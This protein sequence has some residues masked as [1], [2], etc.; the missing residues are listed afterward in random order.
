MSAFAVLY[1]RSGGPL[2]PGLLERVMERL[3]HRGP[4]GQDTFISGPLAMGHWHFWTTPE[5]D[6]ERQPLKLDGLPFTLVF[7][8]RLD[9]REELFAALSISAEEGRSLSDAALVLR[10]YAAWGQGCVERFI[11]E[12]AIVIFDER[13]HTLFCARDHLGDR[14]LFYAQQG[15]RV[16]I[17]SEPWA[18]VGAQSAPVELDER[19]VAY[20]FALRATP[21]GQTLFKDVIELL[22]ANVILI[23]EHG[24]RLQRYWQP[25]YERKIRYKTDQEYADHFRDLLEESVRC[26]MRSTTPVAVLMSGGLDSTSV[27]S[28]AARMIAPQQLTTISYVFDEITA[29]DEREFINLMVD[30][31]NLNSIQIPCDDVWP[32]KNW[33]DWPHNAS[34]PMQDLYFPMKERAYRSANQNKI[35][36][37]LTGSFGDL[38]YLGGNYWL[39]DLLEDGYYKE[40]GQEFL[41]HAYY[42][43][44]LW[45]LQN[46]HVQP[47]IRNLMNAIP[48]LRTVRRK[49]RP[50]IWL[51]PQSAKHLS[52][53]GVQ[54]DQ[55]A[56]RNQHLVGDNVNYG[57]LTDVLNTSRFM[58]E[59]RDPYRDRRLVEFAMSLPAYQLYYRGLYKR[60]L[61]KAM[62]GLLPEP[63][64]VSFLRIDLAAF[65]LY[66]FEKEKTRLI[67]YFQKPGA[68][69]NQSVKKEWI[70]S[71]WKLGD[72][73]IRRNGKLL[74]IPRLCLAFETWFLKNKPFFEGDC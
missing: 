16:M 33:Q 26:R 45:L 61:R 4:D 74:T 24:L 70:V 21:D 39:A 38:L 69:W 63:V 37:I 62:K 64:R 23:S 30:K 66:G 43:G 73:K 54:C 32:F 42:V 65:Y 55:P 13:S 49:S 5:E 48:I 29:S 10:A 2:E 58:V 53:P 60:V 67:E 57:M 8:G 50:P 25:D 18:V 35:R 52:K 19:A 40:A 11:G 9:N 56:K 71:T 15:S 68:F 46:G 59:T 7:D 3:S 28:L 72:K 12:F 47:V 14:T 51:T 17:A 20:Y 41:K 22:P 1:D 36:V 31:W 27:A 6:G 44:L 34:Y